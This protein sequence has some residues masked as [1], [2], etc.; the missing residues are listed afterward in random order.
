MISFFT[1]LSHVEI[2]VVNNMLAKRKLNDLKCLIAKEVSAEAREDIA[3]NKEALSS[4]E[5]TNRRT[6]KPKDPSSLSSKDI[7][8]ARP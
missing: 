5:M 6:P 2:I 1:T 8:W 3:G 4:K 7:D